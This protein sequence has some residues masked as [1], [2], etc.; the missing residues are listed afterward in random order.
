MIRLLH[1]TSRQGAQDLSTCLSLRSGPSHR[2]YLTSA[3][4]ESG[5]QAAAYLSVNDRPM[6]FRCT[7]DVPAEMLLGPIAAHPLFGPDGA[8]LRHGM[9]PEYRIND[10]VFLLET[11]PV[12]Q[13]L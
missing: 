12:W 13:S 5:S 8:L 7:V 10:L 2:I 6:E 1:Y 9:A 3:D 4:C 11:A